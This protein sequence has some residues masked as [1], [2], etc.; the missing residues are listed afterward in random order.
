MVQAT[1]LAAAGFPRDAVEA[2]VRDCIT[3][4]R[5]TEARIQRQ[6]D[7]GRTTDG[8]PPLPEG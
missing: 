3:R 6:D 8:L 2:G 7:P 1:V 4:G 5:R